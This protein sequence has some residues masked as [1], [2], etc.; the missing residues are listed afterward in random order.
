M[1]KYTSGLTVL[2]I[3]L[4]AVLALGS[5]TV[6]L[7]DTGA[8]D[9]YSGKSQDSSRD[10]DKYKSG[11]DYDKGEYRSSYDRDHSSSG[12]YGRSARGYDRDYG[13][14]RG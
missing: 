11:R 13:S 7:G 3:A 2:A 5:T 8:K 4:A 6:V 9:S 1:T 10:T 12:S 14:D